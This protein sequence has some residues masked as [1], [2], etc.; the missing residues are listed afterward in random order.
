MLEPL[1]FAQAQALDEFNE[2]YDFYDELC[3]WRLRPSFKRQ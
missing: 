2:A 1:R 3:D